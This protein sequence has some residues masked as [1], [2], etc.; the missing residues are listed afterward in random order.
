M[1]ILRL[2]LPP[3]GDPHDH[4]TA[5]PLAINGAAWRSPAIVNSDRG[6]WVQGRHGN[7]PINLRQTLAFAVLAA[8]RTSGP[9]A[10]VS[11]SSCAR[12]FGT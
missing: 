4:L 5:A 7:M 12:Q 8:N 10:P 1:I 6:C 9:P 11:M 2:L 3:L